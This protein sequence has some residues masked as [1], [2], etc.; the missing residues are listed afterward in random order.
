VCSALGLEGLG[1]LML[2]VSSGGATV[3]GRAKTCQHLSTP[4]NMIDISPS[5]SGSE[6]Q[7]DWPYANDNQA[8][9]L[10][11]NLAWGS[12]GNASKRVVQYAGLVN[13]THRLK[14]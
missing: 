6:F 7:S 9:S 14:R 13:L 1:H 10:Q 3:A 2:K 5:L 11:W 12:L 8:A 4:V